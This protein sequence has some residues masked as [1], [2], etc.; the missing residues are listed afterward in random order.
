MAC[1]CD[2]RP[3]SRDAVEGQVHAIGHILAVA[4]L[5]QE[6]DIHQVVIGAGLRGERGISMFR[7]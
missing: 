1:L 6:G 4:K 3:C 5:D 2:L 7:L